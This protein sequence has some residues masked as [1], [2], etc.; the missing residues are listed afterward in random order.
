MAAKKHKLIHLAKELQ[1]TVSHVSDYLVKEGFEAPA[2]PNAILSEEMFTSLLSK[3]APQ[4]YKEYLAE[5]APR[6]PEPGG[7]RAEFRREAMEDLMR[8]SEPEAVE[9]GESDKVR[10]DT[11]E[12]LRSLKV[13]EPAPSAPEEAPAPVAA[14]VEVPEAPAAPTPAAIE[15]AP[16]PAPAP[17]E[18]P[19]PAPTPTPEPV[20]S[21]EPAAAAPAPAVAPEEAL[22]PETAAPEPLVAAPAEPAAGEAVPAP[23]A[24]AAPLEGAELPAD[25]A[26]AER[27]TTTGAGRRIVEHE[28]SGG[29]KIGLP[30]FRPGRVLGMHVDNEPARKRTAK[31]TKT[32]TAAAA[33]PAAGAGAGP[34]AGSA[35][36]APRA[37]GEAQPGFR[38]RD[39][40][41][42][43]AATPGA[44]ARKRSGKKTKTEELRL[45]KLEKAKNEPTDLA[46]GRKRK[47]SKKVKISEDEI[48][49]AVKETT[50]AMEGGKKRRKHRKVRG[51]GEL[52]E[53]T[54]VLRVTEFITTNE[55]SE[56]LEV[57]VSDLIKKA[58][59]MGTMVTI[60]QRLE[61][62]LIE[63]LCGDYDFDVEFLSEFEE[64][65]EDAIEEEDE[66]VPIPR[67][68][69]V[70]VMGHVDHGKTSVLDYIRKANVVAGEAGGITQHIGAY[71]V[72]WKGQLITFLDTPG[73]HSF[74]AM[75][76]RGAQVT[77]I[78]VLVVAAD[79]RVQEQTREAIDHALAAKVPIIV[80]VNKIDKPN[81]DVQK[82][83]KELALY[84]ILVED[85][86]GQY[87]CVDIS[88][89]QGTGMD[90][91][92][93]EILT[94][95]EVLELVAVAEGPA[96]AVVIDSKLD[97][98]RGAIATVL[99]ERGTLNKGDIV[100]AGTA[101]GRVR[102]MLDERGNARDTAPPASPV[103][104]LGLD[105]VPQAGDSLLVYSSERDARAVALKRQQIQREQS[106]QRISSF[107]LSSLSQQIA[108]GEVRDLPVIIKGDV[109]GSIGAIAD[110]L[111]KMQN[112]EVR[113][114]VISR[115]VG[116]ITESDV[117][118]A[119]ASGA[120]IIGFHVSP[121][122][123]A[124]ELAQRERVDV[125]LYKVIYEVVEEI[126]AALE[127]MLAPDVEEEIL[128]TAEVRQVFRIVKKAIAG[129]MVV[130]GKIERGAKARLVRDNTVVHEG[131]MSSLKRFK[132]DVREVATGFECG[133]QLAGFNDLREGDLIQ[134]FSLREVVRRLDMA[135]ETP[136]G[137]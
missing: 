115:S 92:L 111:M 22:I 116:N 69:V 114:N 74:T 53:E 99:V 2:S 108:R 55:L 3:Y 20:A 119:K 21:N 129:C 43:A 36:G 15:P 32:E 96:K 34:A 133:I 123:N 82:I 86:G 45:Q 78:V 112:Q 64:E 137:R 122:P 42:A 109:D 57:P 13:I 126:H 61:R 28:D 135:E 81:A 65:E 101:S 91:L 106:Q 75:R 7:D 84:N 40:S 30:V 37:A 76:A 18:E 59:M 51:V 31:P 4:R 67:H 77:D 52:N 48:R 127:G 27:L 128:G 121:T 60:N 39:P 110:E 10:S 33:R 49:A 103:Q 6:K 23:A 89:K 9:S 105:S 50:K 87:Q 132:D 79:D 12:R 85:W 90:R 88:A 117:L 131:D 63:I 29:E 47:K 102:L 80:A 56:L 58:F 54:N 71:E 136:K 46:G 35:P 1:L 16:A 98:G 118:L 17:P 70:T 130:S 66:G 24:E 83:R 113:V 8:A 95:A 125:R 62:A 41:K 44:D 19:A 124:R 94:R 134:V 120:I 25:A 68:P 72:N 11:V 107:T 26:L 100:V 73:H 14:P 5:Q 93:D 97:K 104:I 38:E